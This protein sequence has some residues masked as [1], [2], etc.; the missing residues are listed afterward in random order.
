MGGK[1]HAETTTA[2]GEVERKRKT[3]LT[4]AATLCVCTFCSLGYAPQ[5]QGRRWFSC[6][7]LHQPPAAD[8][9]LQDRHPDTPAQRK[10]RYILLNTCLVVAKQRGERGDKQGKEGGGEGRKLVIED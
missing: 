1:R 5:R 6:K 4:C 7:S 10:N 8:L 3:T 9:R 2:I